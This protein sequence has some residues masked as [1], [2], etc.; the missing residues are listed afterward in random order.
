MADQVAW[1][2]IEPGWR[3]LDAAGN[4]IGKVDRTTGDREA[5]IFD[6]ITI[7]DGGTVLTRARYV[8][9]ERISE[10]R[11]GEI[12]LDLSPEE[13]A[14]LEPY[15]EPTSHPLA[16]LRPEGDDHETEHRSWWSDMLDGLLGRRR[17][18]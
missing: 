16:D 13:T 10:I 18:A 9:A 3:V 12:V 17:S 5:D 1:Y 2:V 11:Q 8:P 15:S 4:E 14:E 6:G 7:G